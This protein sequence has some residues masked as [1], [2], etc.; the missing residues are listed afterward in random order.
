MRRRRRTS[1]ATRAMS[2]VARITRTS[3]RTS[4]VFLKVGLVDILTSNRFADGSFLDTV[5]CLNPVITDWSQ[6]RKVICNSS[7]CD[8]SGFM[9]ADCFR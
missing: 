6:V 7:K 2:E 8:Q 5:V 1:I 4:A 9:H 3:T